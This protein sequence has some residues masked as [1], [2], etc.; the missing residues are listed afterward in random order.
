MGNESISVL[1]ILR[2]VGGLLM[3]NAF[4]SWWFTSTSTW[5]YTGKLIDPAYI[6]FRL[7]NNYVNLTLDELAK[8]DGSDPNL[9]IYLAIN[10]LVYDVSRSRN[11][12]GP[13]GAYHKLSG[14][15][16][17][18]VFVTG[19]LMIPEQYTYDLRGLDVKEVEND[20]RSWQNFYRN[21]KKYWYT[22]IVNHVPLTGEPPAPCEHVKF[23]GSH[24]K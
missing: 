21:N 4:F 11:V 10:G 6:K 18:R 2:M 16:A 9:P 8:Y 5:G 7:T 22:G 19:C 1:D 15:D 20:I 12:Y 17:A 23:L 14:R 24:S 13:K 3:L